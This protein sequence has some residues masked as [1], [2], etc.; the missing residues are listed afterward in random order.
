MAPAAAAPL[1]CAGITTYS[2]LRHWDIGPGHTLG[3]VGLGGLG[4]MAP[5]FGRALGARVVVFTTSEGKGD[6]APRLGAGGVGLSP[7]RAR[8]HPHPGAPA[9]GL[10][11]CSAA[12]HIRSLL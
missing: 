8:M 12:P 1:L 7:G 2:P 10:D 11:T 9:F 6:D 4:H 5:Q 3:V